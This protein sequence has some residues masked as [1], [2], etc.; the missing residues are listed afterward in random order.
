MQHGRNKI[1]A[2]SRDILKPPSMGFTRFFIFYFFYYTFI[3]NQSNLY[4]DYLI[5]IV[6]FEVRTKCAR[7]IHV[8]AV[9]SLFMIL[10][11]T[12]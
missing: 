1:T 6:F 4:D 11:C 7:D 5:D 12:F 10:Y 2:S 8:A 3:I 9:Y